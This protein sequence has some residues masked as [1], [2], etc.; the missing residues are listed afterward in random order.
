MDIIDGLGRKVWSASI[1]KQ[2]RTGY[3]TN[4]KSW[5]SFAKAHR[6]PKRTA[7]I[8]HQ[9]STV[10]FRSRDLTLGAVSEVVAHDRIALVS[11]SFALVAEMPAMC[12]L[13]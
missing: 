11:A 9:N 3:V 8:Y 4:T 13:A 6:L 10:T 2:A 5:F 12:D 7:I 1:A